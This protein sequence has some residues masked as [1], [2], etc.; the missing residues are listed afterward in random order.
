MGCEKLHRAPI[1]FEVYAALEQLGEEERHGPCCDDAY[2]CGDKLT[3]LVD[4]EDAQVEKEETASNQ[5]HSQR[6][7]EE[8]R[9]LNL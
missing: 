4:G 8:K 9:I 1:G 5:T 2:G 6:V 3:A 7:K